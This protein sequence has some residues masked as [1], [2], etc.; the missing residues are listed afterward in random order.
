MAGKAIL[1]VPAQEMLVGEANLFGVR[2]CE[3]KC[4]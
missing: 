2:Q 3:G 1:K 4:F